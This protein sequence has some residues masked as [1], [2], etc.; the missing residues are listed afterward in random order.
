MR[1]KLFAGLLPLALLVPLA[2]LSSCKTAAPGRPYREPPPPDLKATTIDYTETD[3]FDALF[4]SALTNQDPAIVVR[5]TY[6]KP[7][8]GP[9]LN[10]W[11]AAWNRG[12][13]VAPKRTA[14]MQAPL[15]GGVP[16]DGDSIREFRLLIEG[17]MDR[18]ENLADKESAWWAEER[19]RSRR[20]ALLKP[21]NLRFH[22][23]EDRHIQ[24][25]FFNGNYADSYP[26]FLLSVAVPDTQETVQWSRTFECSHC[27]R[28]RATEGAPPGRLTGRGDGG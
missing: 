20:V 9:R 6:E 2:A 3:A 21:Y 27:K 11:I 19:T 18:V 13:T 12:G 15:L 7:D 1:R 26:Q 14:R 22:Q 23:D 25:I 28:R 5:T 8:W 24:L 16:V 17:L 10:A 4:E